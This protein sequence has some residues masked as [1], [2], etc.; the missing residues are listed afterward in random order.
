MQEKVRRGAAG[1]APEGE[2][3]AYP[4]KGY[5]VH[6]RTGRREPRERLM[7]DRAPS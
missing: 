7:G 3:A 6:P 1:G 2:H 5:A 4:R